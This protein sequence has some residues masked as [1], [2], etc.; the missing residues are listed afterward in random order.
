MNRKTY[1]QILDDVARD[2]LPENT[3]LAPRIK[4]RIQKGKSVTMRP[5]M[6][7][8]AAAILILLILVLVLVEVPGVA[9]AIQRWFGYI[10]GIGLVREGQIRQ[11]AAPVVVKRDGI[12]ITVEQALLDSEKTVIIYKV[13]NMPASALP[14][15]KEDPSVC[16]E[17][18]SLRLPD[19]RAL[20]PDYGG[21][22]SNW[23]TSY[24][25][26]SSYPAVP[27]NADTAVLFFPC[28]ETALADKVPANW[29]IPLRFI[30]AP[31]D[32]TA[33]PVIEIATPTAPVSTT[34]PQDTHALNPD[35][36]SLNLD[37]AVQMDDGYL[38]YGTVHWRKG[39]IDWLEVMDPASIHLLDAAGKEIPFEII[40]DDQTSPSRE[41]RQTVFAIKTAP[42]QS[43]ESL[44]LIL[45]S[46]I[47][48]VPVNAG[49][50]FDPGP[51]PRP[52]QEWVLDRE[53]DVGYG[54]SL[55][56]LNASYPIQQMKGVPQ[57]AGL[58]FVM[59]SDTGVSG[60][61]LTDL[62]HPLRGGG[63]GGGGESSPGPFSGGFI[64]V[65]DFPA[66]QIAVDIQ[67][68]WVRL[69]GHWQT[70]WTPPVTG[71]QVT[72]VSQFSACLTR[73]SWEQALKESA[74]LPSGLTGK[75]ALSDALPPSNF[76]QVVVANLDGS[77]RNNI[78]PGDS[79]SFSPDGS[80]MAYT[81]PAENGPSDGLFITDLATGV[82]TLL[83]G[84]ARGDSGPLWSPDGINI[85]FT[86]G[87]ASGLI[88]APGPYTIM[89]TGVD[90]SNSRSLTTG[91][92]ANFAKAWMPDGRHILY[93]VQE[94]SGAALH[95]L[96]VQTGSTVPLFDINYNGNVAVS[97]DGKRVAFE[98]MLP[99][100]KYGLFIS[101]L[102]GS[103]RRQLA[104]GDPFIVTV[105]FWSPDGN[106]VIA[107]V[108]DPDT[109]K[110][111]NPIFA[112]IQAD[113]CQIVPLPKLSGYVS[114]WLP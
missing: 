78:G 8:L 65:G 24:E 30:P 86:R 60:A 16:R 34:L 81:G 105:P 97:P 28:L 57:Q 82:A 31:P 67:S 23:G 14:A 71:R 27:R 51:N 9:A 10:P 50:T 83:P 88:G 7:V 20:T 19:G 114:S 44:T 75:L 45:D 26:R 54:Y 74:P 33:F 15:D 6:K 46:A 79:P 35:D 11:L 49:F 80:K 101:D 92:D 102:D 113:T 90:G 72:P 4:T 38:L 2:Q 63:G 62:A 91:V 25:G 55:R 5:R 76:Y 18:P 103:N 70:Q 32:L 85:V 59:E 56:V 99:L 69:Q 21:G 112:L 94:R 106:W 39:I 3:D 58:L 52:G 98:E 100:D 48:E 61:I 42:L 104:D 77:D 87:P 43:A 73:Q 109:G 95:M 36:I 110:Q 96:D 47:V 66:G 89:I 68:I 84:T 12:S 53:L 108:Q 93:T 41:Q 107:S 40:N 1:S 13:E 22:G 111:P 37:R 64:Y 17:P 29:E